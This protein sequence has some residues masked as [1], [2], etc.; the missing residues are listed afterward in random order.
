MGW[1]Y[2]CKLHIVMNQFGEIACSTLSNWH[3]ADIKMGEELVS[4]MEA[5]LY[6]DRGYISEELK[7][8]LKDQDIDLI[9][10]HRKSMQ[11]SVSE[12]WSVVLLI[13][14]SNKQMNIEQGDRFSLF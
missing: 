9:T 7:N 3:V 8:K 13:I 5:K 12:L 6:G 2:C 10:Y 4:G 1:F 11:F 14:R